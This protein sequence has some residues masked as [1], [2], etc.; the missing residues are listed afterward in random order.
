GAR[1]ADD[2]GARIDPCAP[3][4]PAVRAGRGRRVPDRRIERLPPRW[5]GHD[6][7]RVPA[8]AAARYAEPASAARAALRKRPARQRAGHAAARRHAPPSVCRSGR[9]RRHAAGGGDGRDAAPARRGRAARPAF[10]GARLARVPS[11]RV[12]RA[13]PRHGRPLRRGRRARAEHQP[14]PARSADA[15]DRRPLDCRAPVEPAPRARGGGPARSAPRRDQRGADSLRQRIRGRR[16]FHARVQ[17]A[18]WLHAG[19][20]AARQLSRRLPTRAGL[21]IMD[22][23]ALAVAD[24]AGRRMTMIGTRRAAAALFAAV[25]MAACTPAIQ[26]QQPADIPINGSRVHPESIT[27]DA[28]GNIYVGSVPGTIYRAAAGATSAEPWIEPSAEN[29]LTS[30]FGVFADDARGLLWACNNP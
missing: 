7:D 3:A 11:D 30:L 6:R 27:S 19:A 9:A 17:A 26:A 18:L 10:A 23:E 28:A 20:V 12:H 8:A 13:Q 22:G 4:R 24:T 21:P 2:A 29:G 5:R 14:P 16:A 1:L 15:R 25:A